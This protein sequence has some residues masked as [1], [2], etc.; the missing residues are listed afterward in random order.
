M[1]GVIDL[2]AKSVLF[3]AR[4]RDSKVM[5][6]TLTGMI[7]LRHDYGEKTLFVLAA[8]TAQAADGP[9]LWTDSSHRALGA[10]A[11]KAVRFRVV[12]LDAAALNAFLD[13]GARR[14][15]PLALPQPQGGFTAFVLRDSGVMPPELAAIARDHAA[16]VHSLSRERTLLERRFYVVVPAEAPRR[17]PARRSVG[18]GEPGC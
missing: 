3:S 1:F 15:E 11:P 17:A 12:T 14:G 7:V 2:Q 9:A 10:D 13:D 8:A 16:F 6:F 18:R 4:L 5:A